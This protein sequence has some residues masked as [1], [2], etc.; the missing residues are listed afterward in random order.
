MSR[1]IGIDLGTTNSLVAAVESGIPM[2][3]ADAEG[4]RITPSAVHYPA[5]G[6]PP[7]V[8]MA[9]QRVRALHPAETFYSVKRFMG[10]RGGDIT[11]QEC[12]M[13]Y[14]VNA[15]EADPVSFQLQGQPV[16]PEDVSAEILRKTL[17]QVAPR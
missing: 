2:V 12:R 5:L 15:G 11:A 3:I 6:E 13:A 10:R 9:A 4:Q 1:I 8:G 7:V 16:S 14:T 17:R